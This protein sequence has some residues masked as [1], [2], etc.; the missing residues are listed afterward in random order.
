VGLRNTQPIKFSPAGLS[1]ALDGSNVFP[2]AM[3]LLQNLIPDPTTKNV[4]TCRPAAVARPT[5]PGAL[6]DAGFVSVYK[7]I[8]TRLYGLV[9][10]STNA[11]HDEP[12]VYD[13]GTNAFVALTGVTAAN[14]PVSPSPVSTVAWMP[15][16]MD[17]IGSKIIVTH[18][19][20]TGA[21]GNFFGWFDITTFA[22]PTWNAG[23]TATNPLIAVPSAVKQFGQRAYYIVNDPAVPGT[24]FSDVLDPLTITDATHVLTYG[25]NVPLTALGALPLNTQ[26]TGGVIQS[27]I[28]FKEAA[29]F[30]VTGDAASTTNPLAVNGMNVA[31]GTVA[32]NTVTTTPKGLA[33][34]AVDGVRVI[35]FQGT[36]SDPIGEAGMGVTVPFINVAT[37]SR[38]VSACNANTF[39]IS[40]NTTLATGVANQEYWYNIGRGCWSGPHTFPASMIQAYS[41]T[42]V[43]TPIDV[44]GKL[45]QSDAIQSLA[46]VFIENGFQLSFNW[47]TANLPD[48]Q[49]MAEL[50][51]LETT[52]NIAGSTDNV[53]Y[54]VQFVTSDGGVLDTVTLAIA[55]G[56]TRWGSF[57]WGGAVWSVSTTGLSPVPVNWH[58][59]IVF[60]KGAL[61]IS[62]FSYAGFKIGDLFMRTEQLGYLQQVSAA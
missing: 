22:A 46:S 26:L 55:A 6:P 17:I 12:F 47:R 44:L 51:M 36:V 11:G 32:P 60:R 13:L 16:T 19:G 57:T 24:P 29:M 4:W 43:M 58:N 59:P 33:F 15:P 50:N 54:Q 45:F 40:L 21:A 42:F 10:T 30:Q 23:N 56:S 62:G 52:L 5:F 38:A 8:G 20:Y 14:T 25:D 41:N 39:R 28:V 35:S 9:S 48:V 61:G 37:P 18:P 2:G 1:D 3:Q 27:L 34:L 7:V 49:S 31:V 53:T